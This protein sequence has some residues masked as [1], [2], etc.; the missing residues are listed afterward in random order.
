MT[1]SYQ[2]SGP[3]DGKREELHEVTVRQTQIPMKAFPM[4]GR[5]LREDTGA[6][7]QERSVKVR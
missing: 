7:E 5:L 1:T 3:G 6:E 4:E 2:D